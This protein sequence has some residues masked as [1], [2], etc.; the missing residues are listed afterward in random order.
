MQNAISSIIFISID[1][2]IW[3]IPES[4]L[5]P[6]IVFIVNSEIICLKYDSLWFPRE[7][8]LWYAHSSGT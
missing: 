4:A 8:K 7:I 2:E 1:K 6:R 3:L 5:S